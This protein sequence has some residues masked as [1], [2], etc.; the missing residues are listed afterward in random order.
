MA[1]RYAF[2]DCIDFKLYPAGTDIE[3]LGSTVPEGTITIDY[4]NSSQLTLEMESESAR[5]KGNDAILFNGNR[6]GEFT[7]SAE[8]V[9]VEYLAMIFG[10]TLNKDGAI[11]IKGD[12]P[13]QSY[14]LVGTFKGRQQTNN[15]DKIFDIVLYN[16]AAQPSVD[17]TLDATSIGSFD[18]VFKV[19]QDTQ[20]R[21]AKITPRA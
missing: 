10:G 7:C 1:Q 2:K 3:N 14:I 11:E 17:V 19:L 16:V 5:I 9:E 4:L 6:T 15:Q 21:I 8:C 20:G 13:S 12:A 18:L